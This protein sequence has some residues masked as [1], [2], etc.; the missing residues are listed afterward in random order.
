LHFEAQLV[1]AAT[2]RLI[3]SL[4]PVVGS[5]GD[6]TR[7][8][9]T[10]RQRVMGGFATVFGP[11]FEDWQATS[12]PPSYEAYQEMLAASDDMWVFKPEVAAEHLHHAIAHDSDFTGAKVQLVHALAT[13]LQG[14]GFH[15][16]LP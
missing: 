15:C 5:I 16:P 6:K 11:G 9:E 13:T 3:L 8:I 4:D 10:L 7:V 12:V 14:G 1:D 2:G